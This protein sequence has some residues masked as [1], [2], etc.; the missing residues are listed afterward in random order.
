M[1]NNHFS[2]TA[3]L[4]LRP[5]KLNVFLLLQLSPARNEHRQFILAVLE[6]QPGN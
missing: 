6:F 1:F 4:C 5:L 3:T 2:I